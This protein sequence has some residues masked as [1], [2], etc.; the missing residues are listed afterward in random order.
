MSC[1]HTRDTRYTA[2]DTHTQQSHTRRPTRRDTL[3]WLNL[4]HLGLP[5][6][7]SHRHDSLV[8]PIRSALCVSGIPNSNNL[9]MLQVLGKACNS[10]S[11]G[12]FEGGLLASIAAA[13]RFVMS[14]K[15]RALDSIGR[16]T[17]TQDGRLQRSVCHGKYCCVP[18]S[19][20][21]VIPY[22]YILDANSVQS[23][24]RGNRQKGVYP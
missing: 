14:Q 2:A 8:L 11:S 15:Q 19:S 4:A 21:K 10:G 24:L 22:T 6:T 7:T 16:A 12:G 13:G 23:F 20:E 1:S 18:F 17:Q 5:L 9:V 3:P